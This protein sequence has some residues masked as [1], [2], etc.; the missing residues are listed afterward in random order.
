MV[1]LAEKEDGVDV[2]AAAVRRRNS[3][4]FIVVDDI[5]PFILFLPTR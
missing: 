4:D 3:E 5:V 2:G 1:S